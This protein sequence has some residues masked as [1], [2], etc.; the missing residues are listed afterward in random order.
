M[1]EKYI[2]DSSDSDSFGGLAMLVGGMLISF[3][4]LNGLKII[5]E[6]LK[7]FND[8]LVFGLGFLLYLLGF[9]IKRRDKVELI[10]SIKNLLIVLGL[11]I[12]LLIIIIVL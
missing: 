1:V 9:Y 8:L 10:D 11:I 4:I 3:G 12:L 7:W 6:A 2:G 5:S